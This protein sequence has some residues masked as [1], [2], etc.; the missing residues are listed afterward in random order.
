MREHGVVIVAR[1][2]QTSLRFA[3]IDAITLADRPRY[4]EERMV[5]A[6]TRKITI[7]GLRINYVALPEDPLN[8]MLDR[9]FARLA[10]EPRER[11]GARWTFERA[12][13]HARNETV[14]AD[15]IAKAAMFDN[16]VRLWRRG[17]ESPFLAV[18]ASSKNA[19]VL[20]HLADNALQ[21]NVPAKT[22]AEH[23]ADDGTALGRLLFVRRTSV[24]SVLW[25]TALIYAALWVGSLSIAKFLPEFTR[26]GRGALLAL[27]VMIAFYAI[28]RIAMR[29]RFH[30]RGV[31][32]TTLLGNRTLLYASVHSMTWRATT[33]L[34]NSISTGTTNTILFTPS[35][36]TRPLK[37]KLHRW[38]A[39]D[40][41]LEPLRDGIAQQIAYRL[42]QQ[43]AEG[44]TIAWTSRATF[45]QGGIILKTGLLGRGE[46]VLRYDQPIGMFFNEGY[47]TLFRETWRSP[48]ATLNTAAENF[49]PGLALFQTLM[50]QLH[51]QRIAM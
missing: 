28:G 44:F 39:V 45:T 48:L 21:N 51:E 4:N 23:V 14:P 20:L 31:I 27:A 17:E 19:Y 2:K 3:D 26:A 42:Q 22:V 12:T 36:D 6:L 8:P 33:T 16:E 30:E 47:L 50:Q 25:Y 29:Y 1:G 9:L 41:D 7:D 5:V 38:R 40:N 18:P 49:Y 10:A 35:D 43:L 37:I 32:H 11:S 34:I 46:E 13:L 15:L 24:T